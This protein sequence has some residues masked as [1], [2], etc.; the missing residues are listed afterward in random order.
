MV[1]SITCSKRY[2]HTSSISPSLKEGDIE[3]CL[4]YFNVLGLHLEAI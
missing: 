2:R 4:L 1:D 3:T